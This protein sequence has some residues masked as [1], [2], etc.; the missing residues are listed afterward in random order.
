VTPYREL[1]GSLLYPGFEHSLSTLRPTVELAE[2]LL[3]LKP[4]QRQRTVWR[5][6]GGYGSDDA[7]NW[8]LARD[9]QVLVKGY[10][11]R[12]AHKV[13][14]AIAPEAWQAVREHKWVAVVPDGS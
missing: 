12:R 11:V 10:S 4:H 2:R 3:C 14:H 9:F 5:L 8:L 7:I 1:L 13:V 6:D